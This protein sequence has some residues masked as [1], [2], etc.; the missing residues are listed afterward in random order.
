MARVTSTTPPVQVSAAATSLRVTV[1]R[2]YRA[3]RASGASLITPSQVSVLFRVEA[4]EPVRMG[5]LAHAEKI[6]PASLSKV[7][8]SLVALGLV[9]RV[10]DSLDG[11]VT[12]VRVSEHGRA[13]I[14]QQRAASTEALENALAELSDAER[15]IVHGALPALEKL[16][17]VLLRTLE[18]E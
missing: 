18:P 9:E 13:L 14:A 11:R 17:E 5:V 3:L 15:D 16:A 10:P 6:T 4:T 1:A 8:E 2:I 7:V 12:L